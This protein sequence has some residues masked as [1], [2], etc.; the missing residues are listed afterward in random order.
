MR[1]RKIRIKS[2]FPS[3]FSSHEDEAAVSALQGTAFFKPLVSLFSQCVS[4]TNTERERE[5]VKWQQ[6]EFQ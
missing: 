6:E 3:L 2:L 1:I 4:Q 5:N